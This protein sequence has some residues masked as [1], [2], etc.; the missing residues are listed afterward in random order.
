MSSRN[1]I[2][3][4]VAVDR[5]PMCFAVCESGSVLLTK[6][7]LIAWLAHSLLILAKGKESHSWLVRYYLHFALARNSQVSQSFVGRF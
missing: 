7:I 2:V 1:L 5:L 4:T 6:S 3:V